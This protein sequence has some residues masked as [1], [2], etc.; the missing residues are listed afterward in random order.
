MSQNS[1][2][3]SADAETTDAA[4]HEVS[5]AQLDSILV[6]GG[7]DSVTRRRFLTLG[8]MAGA[9]TLV[10]SGARADILDGLKNFLDLD[11]I[12]LNYAHELEE[13]QSE[14][15][16]RIA[17]SAVYQEL[18]ARERSVINAIALQDRAHFEALEAIRN[19]IGARAGGRFNS[20]NSS[21]SRRPR[22]FTFP[23]SAFRDR[24]KM[25]NLA[26][27][28][29]E[30]AVGA[31][32]GAVDLLRS[33]RTLLTPAAAI[34]GVDGRHLV[35]LRELAGLDPIPSAFEVQIS[36]QNVGNRLDAYGFKGGARRGGL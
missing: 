14:L 24:Q 3:H 1:L 35:V 19:R 32:H 16:A 36:P 8:A 22:N 10:A 30:N 13:L 9:T 29:K 27:N 34:A 2:S 26:I 33:K 25:Y 18:T 17:V 4:P 23:G 21:A 7:F 28:V 20:P 12:V 11:P 15:F 5:D 31:Y 6:R